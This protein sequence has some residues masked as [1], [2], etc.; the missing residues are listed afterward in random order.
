MFGGYEFGN[1]GVELVI[2][3]TRGVFRGG[4]R[5]IIV[6]LLSSEKAAVWGGSISAIV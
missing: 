4:V 3:G 1:I 6:F 5:L 2:E